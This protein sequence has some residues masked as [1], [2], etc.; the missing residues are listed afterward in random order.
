MSMKKKGIYKGAVAFMALCM[1]CG[2]IMPLSSTYVQ[3][4]ENVAENEQN[5]IVSLSQNENQYTF[6]N[7]YITRTFSLTNGKLKTEKI[8]NYRTGQTPK[9]LTP[10]S[11][12][13]FVIKT[14]P[15]E[16]EG[17]SKVNVNDVVGT[18]EGKI[19]NLTDQEMCIRD[20]FV[21]NAWDLAALKRILKNGFGS[22]LM[23]ISIAAVSYTHLM[24]KPNSATM[25]F[26]S[27]EIRLPLRLP[28]HLYME[29]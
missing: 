26:H 3:A 22:A 8:T 14:L 12:E 13:E 25:K 21:K 9:V 10:A 18:G 2:S 23:E 6:G 24:I 19:S 11:S 5:G 20:R 27:S 4:Q 29:L 7:E 1:S 28:K 15:K 17:K 16:I